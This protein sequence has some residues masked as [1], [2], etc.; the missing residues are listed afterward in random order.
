MSESIV[1]LG[2]YSATFPPCASINS[3]IEHSRDLLG[4]DITAEWIS[5]KDIDRELFEHHSGLWI[6]P[7]S[8]FEDMEKTLWAIRYARENQFPCLG[9]SGGF[10]YIVIEYA[11]NVL[12]FVD[13]QPADYNPYAN[14]LISRPAC[15][16]AGRKMQLGFVPGSQ[17]AEIYGA[18]SAKEE[19]CCNFGINPDFIHL[20]KQGPLRI[21]GSDAE[22]GIR[23]VEHPGHL[24][25]IGTLFVPQIRSTHEKPHPLITAFLAAVFNRAA[26]D[27]KAY[28]PQGKGYVGD[29]AAGRT[30]SSLPASASNSGITPH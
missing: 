4:V 5:P 24:F 22:G 19:Y 2:E 26:R 16:F 11:R 20:F 23:V 6:A 29:P 3:A 10:Q 28:S 9:T 7:G 8:P 18:L 30:G 27:N 13:A 12:S 25:F 17:A 15:S 1:L 21:S 14:I